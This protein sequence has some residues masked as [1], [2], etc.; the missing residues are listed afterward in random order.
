MRTIRVDAVVAVVGHR[1]RLG[2]PLGLVV[3]AARADRV[4]VA[5]VVLGLRVLQRVAVDLGG[6]REQEARPWPSARPS[7]LCVPSAPTFSVGM[8][9]SEVVDRAGRAGEV[10]HVVHRAVDVDVAGDVVADELK[11]RPRRCS[12]LAR[13]PVSRLSMPTTEWPRSRSC[14][15]GASR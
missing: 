1:H 8:G 5:P 2:E 6:R 7:A 13:S 10:K 14:S 4:H 15:R 11:S 9:S 3:D 12:M